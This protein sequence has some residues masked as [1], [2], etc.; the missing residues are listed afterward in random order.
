LLVNDMTTLPA[1]RFP[2]PAL[3]PELVSAGSAAARSD[4][5][6]DA[7]RRIVRADLRPGVDGDRPALQTNRQDP[8]EG[9]DPGFHANFKDTCHPDWP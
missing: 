2:R 7:A 4:P 9:L 5:L 1:N 8:A 3:L 6:R